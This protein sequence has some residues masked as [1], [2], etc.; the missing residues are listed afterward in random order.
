V[1]ADAD[2]RDS[3]VKQPRSLQQ[4]QE[5]TADAD[6]LVQKE[7]EEAARKGKPKEMHMA[8]YEGEVRG[9]RFGDT[10]RL[11]L[12]DFSPPKSFI[13]KA[14]ASFTDSFPLPAPQRC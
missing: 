6:A 8:A 7:D 14:E 13:I 5:S 3:R 9:H 12:W 1:R 4:E 2:Q 10:L 11:V